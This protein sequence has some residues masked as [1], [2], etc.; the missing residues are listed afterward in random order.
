MFF[1]QVDYT[2]VQQSMI[3]I[4]IIRNIQECV[5]RPICLQ[6][7]GGL[8]SKQC[9]PGGKTTCTCAWMSVCSVVEECVCS[10]AD[11]CLLS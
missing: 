4:M 2:G 5:Y 9:G 7:A 10:V 6:P 3:T 1:F 11:E 8:Q